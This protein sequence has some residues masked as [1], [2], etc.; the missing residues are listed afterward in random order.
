M[1]TAIYAFSGDPITYGHIDII[2]RASNIF[3]KVIIAIGENPDK[4]YTFTLEQR[5]DMAKKSLKGV[6]NVE[7]T[8][9]EGL[10]IDF[11]YEQNVSVIIKGVRNAED[12]NYENVLDQVGKSQKLGIDTHILFA[13]PKLA[14]ISSSTVRAIFKHYGDIHEYVPFYVKQK[15]EKILHGQFII[16]I[17]G[18]IASGKSYMSELLEKNH[19]DRCGHGNCCGRLVHNIDLDKI[20]HQ[21]LGELEEPAYQKVREKIIKTFGKTVSS[22]KWINRKALGRIVFSDP[23]S[24]RKLNEIMIR[25]LLVRLKKEISNTN[26]TVIL[27]NGA[28]LAEANMLY[29]C[30]NN[31]ISVS[32]DKDLQEQRLKERGLTPQQ[33]EHRINTQW[34][35][36]KKNEIINKII[37]RDGYGKLFT[38]H[39]DR[40]TTDKNIKNFIETIFIKLYLPEESPCQ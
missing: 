31:V 16:G 17:T 27:I 38:F 26:K 10:L 25:P 7:V 4:E 24:L 20:A 30:N 37:T 15:M 13:N 3:T 28:L 34:L 32:V 11:A 39:N 33:I 21:I 22:G 9:F 12:F 2:K 5:E 1:T 14:H 40:K 36:E 8:S 18:P 19:G 35:S 23:D 6:F 29:I